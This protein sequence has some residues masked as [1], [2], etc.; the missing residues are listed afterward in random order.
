M[1]LPN[2]LLGDLFLLLCFFFSG[3]HLLRGTM[4]GGRC[5]PSGKLPEV[6]AVMKDMSGTKQDTNVICAQENK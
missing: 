4:A 5:N 2:G 6:N 1:R 3:L